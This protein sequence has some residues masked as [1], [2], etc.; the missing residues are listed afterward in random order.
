MYCSKVYLSPTGIIG[1][2][3]TVYS[4]L[5]IIGWLAASALYGYIIFRFDRAR[6]KVNGAVLAI[7]LSLE[8]VFLGLLLG[9]LG[10]I[11]FIILMFS[12]AMFLKRNGRNSGKADKESVGNDTRL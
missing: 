12:T 8:I 9:I 2:P 3:I 4:Y 6:V 7:V 10:P 11:L 1:E 5:V